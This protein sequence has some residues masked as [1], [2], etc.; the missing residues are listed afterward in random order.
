[1]FLLIC[2]NAI[3]CLLAITC[4]IHGSDHLFQCTE[5]KVQCKVLLQ[6]LLNSQV[7]FFHQI[8]LFKECHLNLCIPNHNNKLRGC[9]PTDVL[10]LVVVSLRVSILDATSVFSFCSLLFC[11]NGSI[12]SVYNMLCSS[13]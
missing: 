1:M 7:S 4:S 8:F 2:F 6:G 11:S 13:N 5:K 10:L 12:S 9:F 3:F